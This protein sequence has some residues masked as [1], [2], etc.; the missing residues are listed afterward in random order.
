MSVHD[1]VARVDELRL[2]PDAARELVGMLSEQSPFYAGRGTN[3]T[4]RVRG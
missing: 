2:Q 1:L 4:E 3:E